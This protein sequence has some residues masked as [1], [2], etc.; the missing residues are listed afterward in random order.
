MK[1]SI[2]AVLLTVLVCAAVAPAMVLS[3][4]MA[5]QP[6][7][8]AVP[9]PGRYA[10]GE[11]LVRFREAAG[12]GAAESM[13]SGLGARRAK[14]LTESGIEL[15][16]VPGG[17]DEAIEA[18]RASGLVYYAEPNYLRSADY[19]P[20][21]PNF[22]WQW[23]LDDPV[24][25]ADINM[26]A[27]W[28]N[29]KGSPTVVVAVLDTGIA[30]RNGGGFQK[31]PDFNT[32]A[33]T[34]GYDFINDDQYADDDHGHGT[35]V[36]G[37]IAESTNNAREVAGVAFQCTLMPVKVLDGEGSGTDVELIQGLEFASTHGVEVANMSLSGPQTNAALEEALRLARGRGT[38]LCASS[39]NDDD[40]LVGYPA[41]Y[42]SCIAVGATNRAKNRASYS[43]Y[44]SELDVCAPGGDGA[45]FLN[46]IIQMTYETLGNPSSGFEETSMQGTSMACPHV[47]GV[48]ALVRSEHT[49]WTVDEVTGAISSTCRDIGAAG[50]D[51]ETGWGLIDAEAALLAPK[52]SGNGPAISS[53]TPDHSK[54]GADA[55]LTITGANF[56][57]PAKVALQREGEL[58]IAGTAIAVSGSTRI[59][60]DVDLTGAQ[61]GP[62]NLVVENDDMLGDSLDG[63]FVADPP[64]S[65]TW[66]LAEG[67]TSY[68]FEEYV[69]IQNAGGTQANTSVT[70]MTPTG[71]LD[72][73][74]VPVPALSRTTI[75]VNDFAIDTDV[76]TKVTSDAEIIC[77]RSM[78][79]G[80]RVEGTDCIGVEAPA[81]SWY[82]AEGTTDYGF[83]TYLLIQ[84]PQSVPATV[85]VTY[86]TPE[87]PVEK[88]PFAMAPN[89]RETIVVSE[90]LPAEE[91]SFKV[92]SDQ[93]VIAERSMYWDGMRG[94][95]DSVGTV[96]PARTWYIAEGTTDW[97]FDEYVLLQNPGSENATVTLT[98]MTPEG[99]VPQP[100]VTV[101]AGTR[102][103][104]HVDD[105][106]PAE[107]V[108]VRVESDV[109]VIA[110]RAMYWNNGT[111]KA[112]HCAVGVL[113]SRQECFLAEGTTDW[114]FDEWILVQNPNPEPAN[115]GVRYMTPQGP[116][117]RDG[118]VLAGNS[119]VTVHANED[120]VPASDASAYVF[121]DRRIIAERSMYWNARGGGHV[122]TGMMK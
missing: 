107:D 36:S 5:G 102:Q 67:S 16:E 48:A 50:W 101:D 115:I 30:Y 80:G 70:F 59:D 37:T 47:A 56:A 23:N 73:L 79:W 61:A 62:W 21:D 39:G 72:P 104:I 100:P 116:V 121:S 117:D 94:G 92:L 32:T 52:P 42:P 113:Q 17:V 112:G 60:C 29:Q 111:G 96:T 86:M 3:S 2:A 105:V 14:R 31:S 120:L 114:G 108:S 85:L 10:P 82:L 93:R 38:L 35:H 19:T 88:A 26:P 84:N 53:V 27:A 12:A 49:T 34:Q 28:D 110:E 91:M 118:F 7:G 24:N 95:H 81:H 87:G 69:L 9:R 109:G 46:G 45:A 43:N 76:S 44:G 68:G 54:T 58:A 57:T 64:M 65:T 11:V 13:L 8:P 98:Y 106:L 119:R 89:S 77:E 90:D 83:D 97:G 74:S 15:L 40:P 66:Y 63:G 122:S 41:A 25:D 55:H 18:L 20:N 71:S 99:P 78:Y 33:F 51:N 22:G 75:R 103:T 6:A 4:A 1:R